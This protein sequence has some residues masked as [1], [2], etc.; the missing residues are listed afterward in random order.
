GI[1]ARQVRKSHAGRADQRPFA[2]FLFAGPAGAGKTLLAKKLAAFLFGDENALVQID[3]SEYQEKHNVSRLV[4]APPGMIG[5][6]PPG[7]LT[8]K[9]RRR[10]YCVVLLDKIE[11]G[12]PD[13]LLVVRQVLEEGSLMDNVGRRVSFRNAVVIL[14]TRVEEPAKVFP[15]ELLRS[16]DDV[17][18]FRGRP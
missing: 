1:V 13:A 15:P 11:K 9:V 12:H 18:V 2:S 16:L 14:E 6:S 4:G 8:E 10:P 7:E 17:V 3:M 5:Y